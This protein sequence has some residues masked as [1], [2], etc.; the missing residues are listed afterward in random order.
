MNKESRASADTNPTP[1]TV[2]SGARHLPSLG[3]AGG[4][5]AGADAGAIAGSAGLISGLV[6]GD[7]ASGSSG[8][9]VAKRIKPTFEDAYWRERLNRP[10]MN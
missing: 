1:L 6:A 9:A 7:V 3:A 5:V 2:E 4:E 10:E 8:E